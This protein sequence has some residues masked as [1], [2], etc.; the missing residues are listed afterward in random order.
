MHN[1]KPKIAD[2]G[3]YFLY[4]GKENKYQMREFMSP[5]N[6]EHQSD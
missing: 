4:N 2:Y 5:E 6:Y 3:L 1:D